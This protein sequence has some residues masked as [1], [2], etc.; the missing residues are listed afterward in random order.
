MLELNTI[1]FEYFSILRSFPGIWILA[2]FPIFFLPIFLLGLWLYYTFKNSTYDKRVELMHL[3]YACVL[4]LIFSYI[5]KQFVDIQR[6][7]SYLDQTQSLI[8]GTIPAKSF[9][10]DHATISFAFTTWLF[11]TGFKRI[12]YIFLPFVIVMNISRII[13]WVHWPLD[14]VAWMITWIS[15]STIFFYFASKG[16]LVKKLDLIIISIMKTLRLY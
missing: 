4:G 9:P 14:I 5:I 12:G 13:V 3:F 11:F 2:D 10:S 8:M 15:A 1:I 6:P 16:K 7:E